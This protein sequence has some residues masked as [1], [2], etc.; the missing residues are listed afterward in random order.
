MTT[1]SE[2]DNS[3]LS[4]LRITDYENSLNVYKD[5]SG[6]YFFNLNNNLYLTVKKSAILTYVSDYD[7]QW[8]LLAYKLYGNTRLAW[9]LMKVNGVKPKDVFKKISTGDTVKYISKSSVEDILS[10]INKF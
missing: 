3:G 5:T 7:V 9:I 6:N 8:P 2:M 10:E 1:L 4:F